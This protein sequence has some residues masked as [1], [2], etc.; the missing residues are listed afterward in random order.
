LSKKISIVA[1]LVM[2]IVSFSN[3]FGYSL[4][5]ISIIIGVLFFFIKRILERN[6]A[7]EN[8]LNTRELYK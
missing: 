1:M 5:G 8:T 3:F 2:A 6:I 4:A 7:S